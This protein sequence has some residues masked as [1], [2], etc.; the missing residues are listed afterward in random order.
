MGVRC[1]GIVDFDVLNNRGELERQI[2][3]LSLPVNEMSEVLS[4][5]AALAQAAKDVSPDER[6]VVRQASNNG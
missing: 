6:L 4:I 2:E 1:A 3:A 5:Q